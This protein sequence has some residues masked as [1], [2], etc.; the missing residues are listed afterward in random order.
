[1]PLLQESLWKLTQSLNLPAPIVV[2]PATLTSL[3]RSIIELLIEQQ[4]E[5]TVLVK[6]P[7]ESSM[8]EIKRYCVST[9]AGKIYVCNPKADSFQFDPPLESISMPLDSLKEYFL[10]VLSP[11]LKGLLIAQ[12][13]KVHDSPQME[14]T[15]SFSASVVE[16]VLSSLKEAIA[17]TDAADEISS[18][19]TPTDPPSQEFLADL[20]L[21]QVRHTDAS[22]T[23]PKI[24]QTDRAVTVLTETLR[25]KEE[26]LASLVRELRPPVTN[27]KTALRLLESKQ[28]KRNQR[29]RY[30]D[31]L[32]R[33]CD[34]QNSLIVGLLELVQLE[35][36]SEASSLPVRLDDL[37]P[38]IVSTY[39]PLAL[40][41]GIILGYTIPADIPPVACPAAWLRQIII[42]LLNNSL[43]FTQQKGRVY[44]QA[45][46]HNQK[47]VTLTLSDTGVGIEN[48]DLP[49]IFDSFYRGR[50]PSSDITGAGLGLT[51]VK[52]LV[53]R[54]GGSVSVSSK[55]GKGTTFKLLLPVASAQ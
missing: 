17:H 4:L 32:H 15:C 37:V 16:Q 2:S 7:D 50:T 39:Q 28:I 35:S 12:E 23:K 48:R 26:F 51:M 8:E 19:C 43:K 29:Q 30:L 31:L 9:Q 25:L 27:M 1:M 36:N 33:E 22:S 54:C 45:S 53:Q 11:Q 3:V 14:V 38:G 21:K 46:Q 20:L 41:K 10:I 18:A 42:N 5:A 40:E 6:L 34:R 55:I 52:Q 24:S 49:K 47:T 13:A 44:V